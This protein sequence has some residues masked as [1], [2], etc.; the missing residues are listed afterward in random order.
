MQDF[1][2]DKFSCEKFGGWINFECGDKIVKFMHVKD[3]D[4]KIIQ[5]P[6]ETDTKIK[7]LVREYYEKNKIKV[8]FIV[9]STK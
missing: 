2:Y 6:F 7:D 1:D 5:L 3:V 4:G 9:E 8:C